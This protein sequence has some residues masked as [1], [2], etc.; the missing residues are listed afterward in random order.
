MNACF[1]C[2]GSFYLDLNTKHRLTDCKLNAYKY[3]LRDKYHNLNN[4]R[5]NKLHNIGAIWIPICFTLS[6]LSL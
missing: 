3:S 1:S 5:K 6:E 4:F 2:E